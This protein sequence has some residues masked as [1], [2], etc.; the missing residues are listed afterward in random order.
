MAGLGNQYEIHVIHGNGVPAFTPTVTG[1]HYV[2]LANK[3]VYQSVGTNSNADWCGPLAALSDLNQ[4]TLSVTKATVGLGLV[5][6]YPVATNE[7]ATVGT[8][9]LVYM[10]PSHTTLLVD[11]LF[12]PLLDD[13]TAD[14]NNPHQTTA[15]QVG[16]YTK[17]EVGSL[18]AGLSGASYTKGE[19][20]TLFAA[21]PAPGYTKA[22]VDTMFTNI[23]P[24]GYTKAEVDA[25]FLNVTVDAYTKAETDNLLLGVSH[26]YF[27][28]VH[29][30]GH[31]GPYMLPSPTEVWD[32]VKTGSEQ[33]TVERIYALGVSRKFAGNL[34]V[35]ADGLLTDP[36]DIAFVG[37]EGENEGPS[38]VLMTALVTDSSWEPVPVQKGALA[39]IHE[40]AVIVGNN[41]LRIIPGQ[42]LHFNNFE[43]Q[44]SLIY[45]NWNLFVDKEWTVQ[46]IDSNSVDVDSVKFHRT[47]LR[48]L[49]LSNVEV[50][51]SVNQETE[52]TL[53]VR[54]VKMGSGT[55][56]FLGHN[57][58]GDGPRD[59]IA[60]GG[61][62]EA[63]RYGGARWALSGDLV[64]APPPG[65]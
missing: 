24:S 6:N 26:T 11:T 23:P 57:L 45:R 50:S 17:A 5:E 48:L 21:I 29:V 64:T 59:V 19:V 27:P 60:V 33:E 53:Q 61:V 15:A 56:S 43:A 65:P 36:A 46:Y 9:K 31:V 3:R 22:E 4:L 40:N 14:T 51:F 13:H 62:V 52:Q 54:F 30:N 47:E 63:S 38:Y 34:L 58:I 20:D 1:Q 32:V 35:G 55:L 16:A 44:T 10:T 8:S 25:M 41:A 39:S 42:T 37:G 49:S 7:Q 18:L 28:V 12:R 2:D